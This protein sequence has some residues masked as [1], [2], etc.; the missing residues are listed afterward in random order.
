MANGTVE[1][2]RD[3]GTVTTEA[4]TYA[5]TRPPVANG[6]TWAPERIAPGRNE[7]VALRN[8][9]QWG[10]IL[11]GIAA[12]IAS[13]LILSV[14]G[15]AVGSTALEP[16]SVGAN[17]ATGAAIWGIISAIIAFFIGGWIAAKSAAVGGMGSG[18]L[19]GLIVGCAMLAILVWAASTGMGALLG[20]VSGNVGDIVRLITGS[21]AAQQNVSQAANQ[22]QQAVSAQD[23]FNS[24]KDAAWGTFIGIV[25]PL[26][27]A[28][29]GGW[30]GHNTYGEVTTEI[31]AE[32]VR[33]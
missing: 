12:A 21:A 31:P 4:T 30:V 28:A 17:V 14:L 10:P 23:V 22:A 11:A 15:L 6:A 13:L 18:I 33:S 26:I 29:L 25:L 5:T 2:G 16:R 19:N 20:T 1:P 24:V 9:V 8:R 3:R 27:A 32:N 7:D